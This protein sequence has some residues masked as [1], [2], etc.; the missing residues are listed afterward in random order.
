MS[1][2]KTHETRVTIEFAFP[3]RTGGQQPA[4][5]SRRLGFL[6]RAVLANSPHVSHGP[7]VPNG[8]NSLLIFPQNSHKVRSAERSIMP[9]AGP[10][11]SGGNI[12]NSHLPGL[13]PNFI[14]GISK[15]R[16]A[17]ACTGKTMATAGRKGKLLRWID[18]RVAG[19][20]IPHASPSSLL[21]YSHVCFRRTKMNGCKKV[22]T[23]VIIH[24]YM[25]LLGLGRNTYERDSSAVRRRASR[26]FL[27][28]DRER[29]PSGYDEIAEELISF[30]I[31]L[32]CL[33]AHRRF[34]TTNKTLRLHSLRLAIIRRKW[35]GRWTHQ[36]E[37]EG[38]DKRMI[39]LSQ[40]QLNVAGADMMCASS[41]IYT[42]GKNT[43]SYSP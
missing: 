33:A 15:P 6:L 22:D 4:P 10:R 8:G 40:G 20:S 12:S 19:R 1:S 3:R 29:K 7:T 25:L 24:V 16:D 42:R 23:P 11:T 9:K 28:R 26:F 43:D 41:I 17:T 14:P 27:D 36:R 38:R 31:T 34:G 18:F 32:S 2:R 30:S 13:S 35:P 37:R 21:I 5:L 39:Y